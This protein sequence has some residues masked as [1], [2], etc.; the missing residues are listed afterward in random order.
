[1]EG[2]KA[3]VKKHGVEKAVSVS[4]LAAHCGFSFE[5]VGSLNYLDINS[6]VAKVLLEKGILCPS[7]AFISY[8]HT[9]KDIQ[10]FLDAVDC[11]MAEVRKAMDQDSLEGILPDGV[12]VNP[13][14]KRNI[15]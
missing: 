7:Y 13:V 1:M 8:S 3:L 6:V 4:G 14:F 12:R 5:D 10:I 9:E 2:M 15:K 11:A